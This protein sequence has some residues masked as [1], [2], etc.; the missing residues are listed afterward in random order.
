MATQLLDLITGWLGLGVMAVG[1]IAAWVTNRNETQRLTKVTEHVDKRV[2]ELERK[3]AAA[4]VTRD[5]M[6]QSQTET[7]KDV[8]EILS[9]VACLAAI[10]EERKDK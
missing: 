8:K 2:Q 10:L 9:T 6:L 7:R 1:L 5:Q 4:K 3:D